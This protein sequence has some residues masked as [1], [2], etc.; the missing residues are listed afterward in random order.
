VDR[1]NF[2]PQAGIAWSPAAGGKWVV[3]AGAGLFYDMNRLQNAM[4]GESNLLPLGIGNVGGSSL[5]DPNTNCVIFDLQGRNLPQPAGCPPPISAGVNWVGRRIDAPGFLD[6]VFAAQDAFRAAYQVAFDNFPIGSTRCEF[7]RTCRVVAP[8][9]ETP[10]A[11]HFNIGV[12]RELRPGLVLSVD[13]VRN[14]GLHFLMRHEGNRNGA[15]DT[16]DVP[17]AL[18]AMNM[19]HAARNCPAGAAGVDCAITAGA[20]LTIYSN[21]GLGSL[22]TASPSS[23]SDS[24]FPGV[25][26]NFNAVTLLETNGFSTYNGLQVNLRGRLP[27]AGRFLKNPSVVASYALGRLE[28]TAEDQA[29][30]NVADRIDNDNPAGFRGPTSLDRTHILSVAGLFTIPGGVQLNS[31]W[32]AFSALPQSLHLQ[33]VLGP[34]PEIFLSDINGDGIGQDV[35]PGTNRGSYGRKIGCGAR[36]LNRVID[37]YNSTQAGQL[38]P[39]GRALVGAGLFRNDQLTRLGAVSPTVAQAPAGQVCLDSFLTTDVRIARPFKLKGE[40]ITIEPALEWFNL[41][42]VANYDL[43][44]NK[45]SGSL[46]GAPGTLLGTTASGRTNRAGGTGSFVLGAPRS[47]QLALRVTF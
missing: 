5:A 14:R 18:A 25:N 4:F 26:P 12:Q 44:D 33:Q 34:G 10:Y 43:P 6:A 37:A 3:R 39:A 28:G 1:I 15:A 36:D 24:A 42:N 47:W 45:P 31:L 30:L 46:T 23:P 8:G 27:N 22:A 2:A 38:T 17:R 41:F 13:Y 21:A 40:R 7:L 32:K 35:L 11:F 20:T 19:V 16:L 9:Y 29:I